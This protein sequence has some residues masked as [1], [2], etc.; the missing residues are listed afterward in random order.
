[1]RK[2]ILGLL[3]VLSINS[4]QAKDYGLG[5]T[6]PV[7]AAAHV[8][9]EL[10]A[11]LFKDY[12]EFAKV[13]TRVELAV[14]VGFICRREAKARGNWRIAEWH[15]QTG[16]YD[17]TFDCLAPAAFAGVNIVSDGFTFDIINI[18]W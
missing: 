12:P 1:M 2:F 16:N 6:I 13:L 8:L 14:M 9:P 3:L 4:A 5:H 18:K 7:A 17:S 10:N 15:E 11:A